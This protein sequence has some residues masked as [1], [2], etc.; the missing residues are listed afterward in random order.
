[1]SVELGSGQE[2]V[3]V[4]R[5]TT[6]PSFIRRVP[7]SRLA[8]RKGDA[9]FD[10]VH[11]L[12]PGE[13][14]LAIADSEA[15]STDQNGTR[16]RL[17][18]AVPVFDDAKGNVFGL[19]VVETDAVAEAERILDRHVG[20][21]ADIFITDGHGQIWVSS[22]PGRGV[23]AETAT[24]NVATFV[25]KAAEFFNSDNTEPTLVIPESG[26]IAN[27]IRLNSFDP[28]SSVGIILRLAD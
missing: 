9:F 25:P 8:Q 18:G 17:L 2:I 14:R 13:V 21:Q 27:R 4:E 20:G 19:V 15:K 23:K 1:M 26:V 3:R 6:D 10:T 5:H 22:R 11:A 16:P 7:K 28:A 12:N 24:V